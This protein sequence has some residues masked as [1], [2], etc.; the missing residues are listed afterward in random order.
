MKLNRLFF[1]TGKSGLVNGSFLFKFMGK[2]DK[3]YTVKQLRVKDR[4]DALE[5]MA[6]FDWYASQYQRT[7]L[8]D[9]EDYE[10]ELIDA[11]PSDYL[12]LETF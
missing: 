2:D 4:N 10:I 12:E 7:N 8:T 11:L 6:E 1:I 3:Y 5:K 9:L